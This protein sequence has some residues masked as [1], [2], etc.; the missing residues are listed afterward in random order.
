MALVQIYIN[1]NNATTPTAT[2]KVKS[3]FKHFISVHK[4]I[5]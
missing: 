3:T 5:K 1:S 4:C 2:F